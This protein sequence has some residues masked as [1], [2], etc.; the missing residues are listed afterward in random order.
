MNRFADRYEAK[1]A[2][3]PSSP[4]RDKERDIKIGFKRERTDDKRYPA[5]SFLEIK[6]EA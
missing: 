4:K 6:A 3:Y 2:G 1:I 5:D